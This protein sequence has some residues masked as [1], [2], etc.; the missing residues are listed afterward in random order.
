MA[1]THSPSQSLGARAVGQGLE[2]F[3]VLVR[4]PRG[5]AFDV[6]RFAVRSGATRGEKDVWP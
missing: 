3:V 6:D 2:P 1:R 4:R 5:T